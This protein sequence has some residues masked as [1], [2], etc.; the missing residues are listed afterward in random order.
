MA[1]CAMGHCPRAKK[2]CAQ[3]E[4]LVSP[5]ISNKMRWSTRY[6]RNQSKFYAGESGRLELRAILNILEL[7]LKRLFSFE[8]CF[9]KICGK[10]LKRTFSTMAKISANSAVFSEA[11][12]ICC[13]FRMG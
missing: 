4:A 12:S 7:V 5:S 13:L 9:A 2:N 10:I 11:P 6:G 3:A 8:Q 1:S